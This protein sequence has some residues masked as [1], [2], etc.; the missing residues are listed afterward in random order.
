MGFR[1]RIR[2]GTNRDDRCHELALLLST[3]TS[4]APLPS[5]RRICSLAN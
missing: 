3:D 2:L 5:G 4:D 1:N